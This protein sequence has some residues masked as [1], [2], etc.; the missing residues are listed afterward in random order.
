MAKGRGSANKFERNKQ[1]PRKSSGRRY[2]GRVE[3][4]DQARVKSDDKEGLVLQIYE[5]KVKLELRPGQ[6]RWYDKTNIEKVLSYKVKDFY[7][8]LAEKPDLA[9]LMHKVVTS[10]PLLSETIQDDTKAFVDFFKKEGTKK[11][12]WQAIERQINLIHPEDRRTM[13]D[14][15]KTA[16]DKDAPLLQSLESILTAIENGK[17]EL[18]S[19]LKPLYVD[20]IRS[21]LRLVEEKDLK[22]DDYLKGFHAQTFQKLLGS[23]KTYIPQEN[24]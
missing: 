13:F 15:L 22:K 14:T 19:E 16:F 23:K 10:Y 5:N 18:T 21:F 6:M 2:R 3:A 4:G 7:V 11:E 9:N 24:V 20:Y 12:N 1:S 8:F 17:E